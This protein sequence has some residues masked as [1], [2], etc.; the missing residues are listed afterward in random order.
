MDELSEIFQNT[1]SFEEL[2]ESVKGFIESGFV[3]K[4]EFEALSGEYEGYRAKHEAAMKE[5]AVDNAILK[6]G[7][8]NTK[9]IKALINMDDVTIGENGEIKGLDIEAVKKSDG[10]LFNTVETLTDG[11]GFAKGTLG[12]G[13]GIL[14]EIADAMGIKK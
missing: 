14:K 7:G 2:E 8:R 11:T 12:N 9:A 10:Y 1:Q 4:S 13:K 3:P 6:A 5:N